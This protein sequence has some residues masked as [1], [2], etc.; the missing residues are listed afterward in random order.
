MMAD[1]PTGFWSGWVIVLTCVSL[2]TLAWLVLSVYFAPPDKK[3]PQSGSVA[4]GH[5]PVWDT[6]LREG[7]NAPP[8]WWFWMLLGAMVFSLV[9]LMLYPGLGSY[10]GL[11]NWSQGKRLVSSYEGYE[12]SFYSSR[13]DIANLSLAELQA[14]RRLMDTADRIFRRECAACHG[15]DGRGQAALFPNLLD[16]DWQ[17]GGS[18]EQIEQTLRAGRNANMPAWG[19]MLGEERTQDVAKYL[20]DFADQEH[21]GRAVYEQSCAA[22]HGVDGA[23]NTLLGAPNLADN[24]WLYGGDLDS[25]LETLRE[26]RQ[27]RMPA[28]DEQRLDAAQLKLIIAKLAR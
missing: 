21:P 2:A 26:G 11:L 19:A 22:C 9:Y 6:D 18:P 1:L 7:S 25:I 24:T 16:I 10:E 5:E 14:D 4:E 3:P 15:T 17:W 20:L 23:G 8:L 27:G 12:E 28:F 13:E